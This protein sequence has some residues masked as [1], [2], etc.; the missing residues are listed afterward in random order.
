MGL[1]RWLLSKIARIAAAVLLLIGGGCTAGPVPTPLDEPVPALG[2]VHWV[3]GAHERAIV[4]GDR[5]YQTCGGTLLVLDS[6]DGGE[7]HRVNLGNSGGFGAT[8]DMTL[9]GERAWVVLEDDAVVELELPANAEPRIVRT[10]PAKMLGIQ[11]R[12]LSVVAGRVYASGVGGI[13]RLDDPVRVYSCE[14]DAGRVAEG[15]EGMITTVGRRVHSVSDGRYIGSATD[16][17]PVPPDALSSMPAGAAGD[18]ATLLFVRQGP[19]SAAVGLMSAD[20]REIDAMNLSVTVPGVVKRVRLFDGRI[21]IVTDEEI[22]A[23]ALTGGF[24]GE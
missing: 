4:A 16:L 21:W 19:S 23:Y 15:R 14:A 2:V 20:V 22:T 18:N 6:H 7:L 12:R 1:G 3:G 9:V 5:W 10:V 13:T 11:P 24:H 8:V 17:Q